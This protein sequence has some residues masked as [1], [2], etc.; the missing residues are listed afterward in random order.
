MEAEDRKNNRG[1]EVMEAR[2]FFS[3]LILYVGYPSLGGGHI[4]TISMAFSCTGSENLDHDKS[5]S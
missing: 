1:K 4:H 3:S 2:S 5:L